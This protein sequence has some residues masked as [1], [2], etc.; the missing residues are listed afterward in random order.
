MRHLEVK[1]LWLQALLKDGRVT[2]RKIPGT[3]NVS[4]V[5]TKYSDKVWC[6]KFESTD[7]AEESCSSI[8]SELLVSSLVCEMPNSL[9]AMTRKL[10][11]T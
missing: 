9:L 8:E 11:S 5:L 1:D 7:W 3:H 10:L 2:L 6:T 4:D